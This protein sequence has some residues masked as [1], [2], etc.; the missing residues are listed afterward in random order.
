MTPSVKDARKSASRVLHRIGAAKPMIKLR[1]SVKNDPVVVCE[2]KRG[3]G[4]EDTREGAEWRSGS[5]CG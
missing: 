1:K 2:L 4:Q 3:L 5:Y